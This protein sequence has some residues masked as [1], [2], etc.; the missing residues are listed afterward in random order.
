MV[1]FSAIILSRDHCGRLGC[2]SVCRRT[3]A[4]RHETTHLGSSQNQSKP[5]K[6]ARQNPLNITYVDFGVYPFRRRR[7]QGESRRAKRQLCW[8][9]ACLFHCHI[10]QT[11]GHQFGTSS[12][13]SYSSNTTSG[14]WLSRRYTPRHLDGVYVGHATVHAKSVFLTEK[15]GYLPESRSYTALPAM[16]LG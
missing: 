2:Q 9:P 14:S 4:G 6:H 3:A 15:K 12:S 1:D 16:A 7:V 11:T 13:L 8:R 10:L 5:S